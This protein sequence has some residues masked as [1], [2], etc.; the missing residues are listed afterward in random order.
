ADSSASD[1]H[2]GRPSSGQPPGR[3]GGGPGLLGWFGAW[4]AGGVSTAGRPLLIRMTTTP[5]LMVRP[6]GLVPATVFAGQF[7]FT[8]TLS[9]STSNPAPVSRARAVSMDWHFTF[10]I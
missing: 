7:E 9:T 3:F 6:S 10:G 5:P 8:G 2:P 4:V 1:R